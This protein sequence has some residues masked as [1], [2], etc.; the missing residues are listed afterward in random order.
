MEMII[1]YWNTDE[2][3]GF[4]VSHGEH[5]SYGSSLYV[6]G[7]ALGFRPDGDLTGRQIEVSR[8]LPPLGGKPLHRVGAGTVVP[9]PEEAAVLRRQA[10]D[11]IISESVRQHTKPTIAAYRRAGKILAGKMPLSF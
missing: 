11:C 2:N 10:A 3:F 6:N 9:S 4:A 5:G 1:T 8:V 7:S